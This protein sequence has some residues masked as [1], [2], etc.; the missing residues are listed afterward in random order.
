[1]HLSLNCLEAPLPQQGLA[2]TFH[3][4]HDKTLPLSRA[5][6]FFQCLDHQ[7]WGNGWAR[8]RIIVAVFATSYC[9]ARHITRSN[10][11]VC[12]KRCSIS[13]L[14]IRKACPDCGVGKYGS[15]NCSL[16]DTTTIG[17]S[18]FSVARFYTSLNQSPKSDVFSVLSRMSDFL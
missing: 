7:W 2:F 5:I 18:L 9:A 14:W 13:F 12:L 4:R 8:I 16:K 17:R 6:A 1:M 10:Y 3:R 11:D 15:H